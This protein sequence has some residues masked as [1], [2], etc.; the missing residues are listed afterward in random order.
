[1]KRI[2]KRLGHLIGSSA[3]VFI[4]TVAFSLPCHDT[5]AAKTKPEI[6]QN[7][8]GATLL[9]SCKRE[10]GSVT[11]ERE[12]HYRAEFGRMRDTTTCCST[13]ADRACTQCA[14]RYYGKKNKYTYVDCLWWHDPQE[15]DS[16]GD[17]KDDPGQAG[18]GDLPHSQ[19]KENS[20]LVKILRGRDPYDLI[21]DLL[22]QLE[23]AQEENDQ[24]IDRW[25]HRGGM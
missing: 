13:Q 22:I 11:T 21:N 1:M 24:L 16:R 6:I 18:H 20:N 4:I 5:M 14:K 3:L 12:F 10:P 8:L 17:T 9:E 25:N 19:I 7:W 23:N 2:A 15:K